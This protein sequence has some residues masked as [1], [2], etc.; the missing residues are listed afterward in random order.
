MSDKEIMLVLRPFASFSTVDDLAQDADWEHVESFERTTT[1]FL[2]EIWEVDHA[3]AVVRFIE[4]HFV[5]TNYLRV[6]GEACERVADFIRGNLDII[7]E[8]ELWP[9]VRRCFEGEKNP[10]VRDQAE[11][12]FKAYSEHLD[13]P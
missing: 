5:R 6:T 4:D 12:L 13:E 11:A 9:V 1:Q 10:D 3:A 7:P 2:E 8:E